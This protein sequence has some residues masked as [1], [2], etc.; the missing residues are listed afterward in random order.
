MSSGS[1]A[2]LTGPPGEGGMSGDWLPYDWLL[3]RHSFGEVSNF[4]SESS[5]VNVSPGGMAGGVRFGGDC[6][7]LYTT[8]AVVTGMN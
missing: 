8:G 1:A 4:S 7:F 5:G 6:K 3:S 2:V